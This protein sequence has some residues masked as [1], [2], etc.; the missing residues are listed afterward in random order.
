MLVVCFYPNKSKSIYAKNP[1]YLFQDL[2]H[3][4]KITYIYIYTLSYRFVIL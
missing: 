1:K 3:L 2:S 4:K